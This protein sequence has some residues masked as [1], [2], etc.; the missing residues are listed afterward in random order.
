MP[1]LALLLA[2]Q[3]V[4]S[5]KAGLVNHV[6]GEVNVAELE[7]ARKGQ[8]IRTGED[9]YVEILL[10]PGSFLRLGEH[11]EAV[12]D[13]VELANVSLR[14]VRG[15]AVI[16]V[17]QINKD[18][19]LHIT[20][21]KLEVDIPKAGIY[22]FFDGTVTVVE[23][24]LRTKSGKTHG[25]GWQVAF[26]GVPS[27]RK[28]GKLASTSLDV[29]S[30][31]RSAEIARANFSLASTVRQ[32]SNS[33][34][35]WLFDPSFGMYTYM[36]RG[37]FRS[38]YGHSY[39]AAGHVDRPN[40]RNNTGGYPGSASFPTGNS[41]NSN[42]GNTNSGNSNSGNVGGG[43]GNTTAAPYIPPPPPVVNPPV[44]EPRTPTPTIEPLPAQ[45]Q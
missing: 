15:A 22:R 37:N 9:G 34:S 16:E 36:P 32:A 30:Q 38:S 25:K 23:G 8:P 28:A 2:M 33:T 7:M 4:V 41:G 31:V 39:Y 13:D 43:G 5:V 14:V 10:T 20:S 1:V 26:D 24:Q 29:Y 35:F 42:S 12:L 40:Y 21:G 11:S 3:F 17:L 44:V 19:P 6:Q 18:H 27:A 45:Q